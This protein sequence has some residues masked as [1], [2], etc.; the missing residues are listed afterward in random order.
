LLVV[1][2]LVHRK[3]AEPNFLSALAPLR[4]RFLRPAPIALLFLAALFAASCNG[5]SSNN[6]APGTY[7]LTVTVTSGANSHPLPLTLI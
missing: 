2:L 6:V 4:W 3:F 5:G 7:Q 1:L